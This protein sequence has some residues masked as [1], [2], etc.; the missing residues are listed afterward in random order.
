MLKIERWL[1][2]VIPLKVLKDPL[3]HL[4]RILRLDSSVTTSVAPIHFLVLTSF[5]PSC[6][7]P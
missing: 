1:E 4:R 7:A 5:P 3:E 2:L 6:S